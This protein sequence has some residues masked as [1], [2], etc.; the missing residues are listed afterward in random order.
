MFDENG[1][2]LYVLGNI[3]FKIILNTISENIVL[4]LK[5]NLFFNKQKVM[6]YYS[7]IIEFPGIDCIQSAM[8]ILTRKALR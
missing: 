3:S 6:Y 2:I 1:V 8:P 4:E 7:T 5:Q